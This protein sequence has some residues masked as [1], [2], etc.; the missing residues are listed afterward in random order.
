MTQ[1][2]GIDI[3]GTGIKGALVDLTTG[4][5]ATARYRLKTPESRQPEDVLPVVAQVVRHFHYQ[6]PLGVGF[7][8]VVTAGRPRTPF[9]AYQITTWLDYPVADRIETMTGCPVTLVNDAD[10]AGLAEMVYGAGRGVGGVVILL[11]IGT[12]I[13]SAVFVDGVL[14][15]NTEFGHLYLKKQPEVVEASASERA[16]LERGLTWKAWAVE[17]DAILRH[18]TRIFTPTLFILGGGASK[19]YPKFGPYL[20]VATPVAPAQSGNHA[21]IIGAALAAQRRHLAAPPST[22]E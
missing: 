15:P 21:G 13:G 8:A 2:L 17:M 11:T 22:P 7:P 18:L 16:R 1:L 5:L 12:G 19:D 9:T 3:G 4:A 10:A 20:T 14:V 6:G